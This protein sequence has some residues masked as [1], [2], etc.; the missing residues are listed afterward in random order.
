M[1]RIQIQAKV[2]PIYKFTGS[3]TS[4]KYTMT[5]GPEDFP[6]ALESCS[7]LQLLDAL[8]EQEKLSR[9]WDNIP[10]KGSKSHHLLFHAKSGTLL[11]VHT[12]QRHEAV[13]YNHHLSRH[14]DD[15]DARTYLDGI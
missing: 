13:R 2:K 6:E 14:R 12:Y 1:E 9:A 11:G 7:W 10:E 8:Q 5:P 4:C 3:D 15:V